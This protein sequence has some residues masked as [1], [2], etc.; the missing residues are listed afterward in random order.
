ME[1][2]VVFVV[3][4]DPSVREGIRRLLLALPLPV[5]LFGSAEDFLAGVRPGARG[6]LGL[7]LHLRGMSGL[8]L[9]S[10]LVTEGWKL[11]TIIVTAHD[12]DGS[13]EETLRL[14]AIAYLLK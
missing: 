10:R 9:Q 5:R 14:G 6:C 8:Q 13:R 1:T 3:D 7:D 11:P 12:D 2:P 4:D